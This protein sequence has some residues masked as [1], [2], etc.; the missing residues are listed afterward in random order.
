MTT[1]T[2]TITRTIT[3]TAPNCFTAQ[4]GGRFSASLGFDETLGVTACFVM[5]RGVPYLRN[6]T[7]WAASEK[8]YGGYVEPAGLLP[9]PEKHANANLA[10][11]RALIREAAGVSCPLIRATYLE[12]IAKSL[13]V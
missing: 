13:G 5:G 11:A 9:A 6:Y 8:H 7:E 2:L 1:D 4:I 12:R 10:E 3:R